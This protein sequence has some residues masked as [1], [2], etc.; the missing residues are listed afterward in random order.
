MTAKH[1]HSQS[2]GDTS[3][4]HCTSVTWS[5]KPQ[6]WFLKATMFLHQGSCKSVASTVTRLLPARYR[7]RIPAEIKD[8]SPFRNVQTNCGAHSAACLQHTTGSITSSRAAKPRPITDLHFSVKAKEKWS[9]NP[10]PPYALMA[11][12]TILYLYQTQSTYFKWH[13]AR[14]RTHL[15]T[16]THTKCIWATQ[17]PKKWAKT[18]SPAHPANP[19]LQVY[20]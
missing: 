11:Y 10:L 18:D 13:V 20:Q 16:R 8:F 1:Q 12:F 7:A 14:T 2:A 4:N 9:Y 17:G 6:T 15:H 3:M 19:K 5:C